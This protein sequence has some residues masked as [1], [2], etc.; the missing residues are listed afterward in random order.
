MK[1][2]IKKAM[3]ILTSVV[4]AAGVLSGCGQ[5]SVTKTEDVNQEVSETKVKSIGEFNTKTLDGSTITEESLKDYDLTMI[6]IWATYCGPCKEEMKDLAKLY[7]SLPENVNLTSIC[8]D[9]A[10]EADLAQKIVDSNGV[11]FKVIIPDDKLNESFLNYVVPT[12]FFVDKAGNMVG[13]PVMGAR[14]MEEYM[15]E[16]QKRLE[17]GGNSSESVEISP[18]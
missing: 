17:L 7:E 4:M 3:L 10:D 14:S 2:G 8:M 15:N 6:N 13:E 5:K 12:T 9:A 1:R 18:N 16:I 11:K